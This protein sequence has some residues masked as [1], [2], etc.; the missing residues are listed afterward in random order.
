MDKTAIRREVKYKL[1]KLDES[2]RESRSLEI[3]RKVI[4][5]IKENNIKSVLSYM[6]LNTEVNV[7]LINNY[8]LDTG[9]ELYLPRVNGDNIEPVEFGALHVGAFGILEPTGQAAEI[10]PDIVIT[11]VMAVS[12]ELE[13]LGKGKGFYDRYFERK[14]CLKVAVAF[15][16]QLY[17]KLPIEPH[18]AKM[19]III[20]G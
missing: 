5:I 1:L 4:A 17:D 19:D 7:K 12:K 18:D 9:I 20:V 13:R 2:A 6:P 16:E 11:P 8:C 15:N 14:N 10:I 3:C